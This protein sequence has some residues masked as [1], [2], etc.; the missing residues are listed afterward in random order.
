[1]H[2]R[3][4]RY[5]SHRLHRFKWIP[6]SLR[7]HLPWCVRGHVRHSIRRRRRGS[8]RRQ[9]KNNQTQESEVI[10]MPTV[11]TPYNQTAEVEV[12]TPATIGIGSDSYPATIVSFLLFKSGAKAG[13]VRSIL[14]QWDNHTF[15]QETREDEY[16]RNPDGKI[17]VFTQNKH[18]R[19]HCNNSYGLGIGRRRYYQDPHF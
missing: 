5:L 6:S 7:M 9:T 17:M 4:S 2:D 3:A 19:W 11:T 8:P 15:N 18:H 14:V 16:S 12:G 10:P 13:Q 1:M